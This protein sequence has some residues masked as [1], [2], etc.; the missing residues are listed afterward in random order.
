MNL[1]AGIAV[2]SIWLAIAAVIAIFNTRLGNT[3]E[4]ISPFGAVI[5]AIIAASATYYVYIGH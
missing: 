1:D 2:A 4:T 3:K 5:L